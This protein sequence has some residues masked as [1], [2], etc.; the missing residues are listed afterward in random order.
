MGGT[1]ETPLRSQ[2]F[3]GGGSFGGDLP[4]V[5]GGLL[6]R[7]LQTFLGAFLGGGLQTTIRASNQGRQCASSCFVGL[8]RTALDKSFVDIFLVLAMGLCGLPSGLQGPPFQKGLRDIGVQ[9]CSLGSQTFLLG[10]KVGPQ[11][12]TNLHPWLTITYF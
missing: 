3:L 9:K 2:T 10:S 4:T 6:W 12:H 1:L 5:L 8:F 11:K 7:G